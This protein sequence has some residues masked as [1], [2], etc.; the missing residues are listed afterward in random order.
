MASRAST[1]KSIV[2]RGWGWPVWPLAAAWGWSSAPSRSGS[3]QQHASK[4]ISA[5]GIPTAAKL[6]VGPTPAQANAP[7]SRAPARPPKLKQA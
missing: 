7:P 6:T 4:A 5:S 1:S 3:S 2:I